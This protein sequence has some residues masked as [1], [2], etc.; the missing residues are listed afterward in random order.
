VRSFQSHWK[1]RTPACNIVVICSG[2]HEK[3]VNPGEVLPVRS[4][5]RVRQRVKAKG[6]RLGAWESRATIA[7]TDSDSDG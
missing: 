2:S 3:K 7:P 5:R 4:S 1:I 6:K